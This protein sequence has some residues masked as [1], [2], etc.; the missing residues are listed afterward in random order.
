MSSEA[1]NEHISLELEDEYNPTTPLI[2]DAD[3]QLNMSV[4]EEK[5]NYRRGGKSKNSSYKCK[6]KHHVFQV[7]NLT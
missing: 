5:E 1:E 2:L 4:E 7:S 6:Y 3:Y